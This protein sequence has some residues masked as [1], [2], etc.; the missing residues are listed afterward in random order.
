MLS[1][2][3]IGTPALNYTRLRIGGQTV[4]A[5][6]DVP[7]QVGEKLALRVV[8]N[9]PNVILQ[10]R[11]PATADPASTVIGRGMAR[12]LPRQGTAADTLTL[13][14]VLDRLASPQVGNSA[15][16]GKAAPMPLRAAARVFVGNLPRSADLAVPAR[17]RATVIAAATP[18]EARLRGELGAPAAARAR[19]DGARGG[20]LEA[21]FE[22][23]RHLPG[24]P[25]GVPRAAEATTTT[26]A[27]PNHP[28]APARDAI[29]RRS[30]TVPTMS[31]SNGGVPATPAG[32]VH[33]AADVDALRA[34][35]DSAVARI[36]TQH[37]SSAAQSPGTPWHLGLELPVRHGDRFDL[38][39]FD[40]EGD[41]RPAHE[42][43]ATTNARV[44]LR[45]ALSDTVTFTAHVASSADGLRVRVA[46]DDA[47]YAAALTD[48]IAN[49]EQ[50]LR[51]H[52][53]AVAGV[54]VGGTVPS[55]AR[56][57]AI[58]C[59]LVDVAV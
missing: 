49:L 3:V 57:P 9:S 22:L 7:L 59:T 15:E 51:A 53:L 11:T 34:L 35:V 45:I 14:R 5:R 33:A 41:A 29:D 16:S 1:A 55:L 2:E 4:T 27:A 19:A 26:P 13:V 23:R 39:Q 21:L 48:A 58:P 17:L 28:T 12:T 44:T 20:A 54:A 32:A 52:N 38:W 36:Q 56:G 43:G 31:T 46:S 47:A 30:A 50:A 6:N 25:A 8:S 37:L 18:P 42:D 10:V 40:F 24:E